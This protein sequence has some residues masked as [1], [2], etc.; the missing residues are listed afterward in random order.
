[1][2]KKEELLHNFNISNLESDENNVSEDLENCNAKKFYDNKC[3]F[4]KFNPEIKLKII[5]MIIKEIK[6]GN[7]NDIINNTIIKN[8]E[9]L[10]EIE[11]GIIY[12]LTSSENQ[13]NKKYT[14]ISTLN[15]NECESKIKL[16]YNISESDP[17]T[18]IIP[19]I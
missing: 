9:D 2:Y 5:N 19:K 11:N 8:Q 4:N 15:L 14:N 13:K 18:S 16:H 10:I 1:M 12:Q 7:M 17:L 3:I 6:E